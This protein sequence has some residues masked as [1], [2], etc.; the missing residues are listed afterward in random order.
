MSIVLQPLNLCWVNGAEDDPSDL[1]AHGDVEFRIGGDRL[2]GEEKGRNL[3]VSAASLYLLRTLSV[4][5]TRE[6]PVGE[7]LFPCCG[8]CFY[9]VPGEPDVVVSGCPNGEDFEVL[10]RG[11]DV[12]IRATDGC[13]WSVDRTIWREAVFAFADRVSEFFAACSPK[14]P[15][16]DDANG[17]AAFVAE[18]ERRRGLSFD[19]RRESAFAVCEVPDESGG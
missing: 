3:T 9:A 1:C 15:D 2:L 11:E 16:P 8:F 19:N 17:F 13:E 5:H 14:Q 6:S 10:L 7:H 12:A 4:S 18:W